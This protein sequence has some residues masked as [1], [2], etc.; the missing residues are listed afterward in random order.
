LGE[1]QDIACLSRTQV[2]PQDYPCEDFEHY[3]IP[4]FDN[5]RQPA[6]DQGVLIK[7]SKFAVASDCV[8]VSKLNPRIP[9]IWLPD[10]PSGRR[11]IASTE[12]LVLTPQEGWDRS[13]LYCQF[14]NSEF[15]S[16]LAQSASGTSN[17]HQRIRPKDFMRKSIPLPPPA[18]R[19]A[20]SDL[21]KPM[22]DLV[23]SHRQESRQLAAVRDCLLPRLL[24]GSIRSHAAKSLVREATT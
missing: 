23:A 2:K 12:F 11:Q 19:Q 21:V 22:L 15:Q 1:V 10:E 9:R 5:A 3:S 17:S 24:S 18:H 4:A 6:K 13:Y 20:F 14:A 7:S 8:L 16:D